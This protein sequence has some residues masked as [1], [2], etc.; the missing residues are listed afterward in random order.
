MTGG[1]IKLR[2]EEE[3]ERILVALDE[4]YPQ[5][6]CSLDFKTP[7]ELLVATILSAQCTDERVNQVTPALFRKYRK[8]EDY[9]R[10]P[11]PELE[12]IMRPTGFFHNKAKAIKALGE[13]LVKTHGGRVPDS[14]E[15]LVKLPGV[16]R[17]TANVVLGTAFGVPGVVVD[18]H[19]GRVA[20]RLGLTANQD[21]VKVEFDLMARI[22]KEKWT[23]FSHQ[24]ILHGRKYCQARKPDC[25]RCPLREWCDFWRK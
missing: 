3:V 7:L 2:T 8:A 16:G 13:A 4:E 22:P 1:K 14:L 23:R 9:A 6:S 20:Q 24:L 17:K 21:P 19:V 10:S 11:T 12:A 18:T 25:A 5:A 15:A